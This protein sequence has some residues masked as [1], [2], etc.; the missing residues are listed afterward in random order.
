MIVKPLGWSLIRPHIYTTPDV[1]RQADLTLQFLNIWTRGH[2]GRK[3]K[4]S[5]TMYWLARRHNFLFN[6]VTNADTVSVFDRLYSRYHGY[7]PSTGSKASASRSLPWLKS[8]MVCWYRHI[9]F[10]YERV[11]GN[12]SFCWP[13]KSKDCSPSSIP[14]RRPQGLDVAEGDV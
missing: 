14:H 6:V 5:E 9:I 4:D 12:P 10:I 3:L 11:L 2:K 13:R 8:I 1:I 7:D